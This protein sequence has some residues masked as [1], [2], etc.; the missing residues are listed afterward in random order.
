VEVESEYGTV[1]LRGNVD[2]EEI[3]TIAENICSIQP[4]VK[5]VVNELQIEGDEYSPFL[6]ARLG[7]EI[8]KM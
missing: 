2:S 6:K 7:W 5:K 8:E 4:G 3:S 1:T